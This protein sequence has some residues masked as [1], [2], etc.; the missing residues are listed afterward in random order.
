[1]KGVVKYFCT[2]SPD[3]GAVVEQRNIHGST[4][5]CL[6]PQLVPLNRFSALGDALLAVCW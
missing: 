2:D 3:R 4:W 1:M 6:H 5:G